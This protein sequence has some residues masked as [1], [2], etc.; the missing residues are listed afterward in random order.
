VTDVAAVVAS[1][2]VEVREPWAVTTQLV[3]SRKNDTT[4]RAVA[5]HRFNAAGFWR[6][7][8]VLGSSYNCR[9]RWTARGPVAPVN[10]RLGGWT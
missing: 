9:S 5:C 6:I 10:N 4:Y 7:G 2:L 3:T 1:L 8:V